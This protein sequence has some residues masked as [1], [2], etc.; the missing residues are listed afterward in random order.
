MHESYSHFAADPSHLAWCGWTDNPAAHEIVRLLLV[1]RLDEGKQIARS[2]WPNLLVSHSF[3]VLLEH[4]GRVVAGNGQ[5]E[6]STA[7][8]GQRR[9]GDRFDGGSVGQPGCEPEMRPDV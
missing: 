2:N 1:L 8:V 7:G 4:H 3:A 5:A 6:D 9:P